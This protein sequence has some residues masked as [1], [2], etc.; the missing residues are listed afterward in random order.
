M[1]DWYSQY[2]SPLAK[3]IADRPIISPEVSYENGRLLIHPE[4]LENLAALHLQ[5]TYPSDKVHLDPE[6]SDSSSFG[7]Q[8]E[9]NWAKAGVTEIDLAMPIEPSNTIELQVN[10]EIIG[11]EPVDIGVYIEAV[12]KD[13]RTIGQGETTIEVL[14]IPTEFALH[15]NYPNP[16]NP[17]TT[18]RYD[19]PKAGD[20]TLVVYDLLGREVARLLD[21]YL[22]AGYH[23]VEWNGKGRDRR[24]LSSGVYIVRLVSPGYNKSIKLVLLK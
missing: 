6:L 7:L 18:I 3:I 20:V 21:G 23:Q 13:G 8:L 15:Q 24:E 14:P 1:W 4:K 22:E 11:R 5:I 9:R 16:F 19:L 17:N 12:D 2:A 10:M